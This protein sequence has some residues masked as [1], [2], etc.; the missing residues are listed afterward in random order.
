MIYIQYPDFELFGY[1][2]YSYLDILNSKYECKIF[3][4]QDKIKFKNEDIVIMI[5]NWS[6]SV[7]NNCSFEKN[8]KIFLFN[9]DTY[10]NHN[11][12]WELCQNLGR[13]FTNEITI[14]DYNPLNIKYFDL[15]NKF[16]NIKNLYFPFGYN[17]F[18][19]KI[20][21]KI[22]KTLEKDIDV[23]F[24]GWY[25]VSNRRMKILEE[26]SKFCKVVLIEKFD[27]YEQQCE[28]IKRSKI[29]LNIYFYENNKVFDYFRMSNLISN[30]IFTICEFPEN[31]DLEI[32]KNLIEYGKYL[33]FPKY[34]NI[35]EEVKKYLSI[36]EEERK[37]ISIKAKEWFK[38]NTNFSQN[39][40]NLM[41]EIYHIRE[42]NIEDY[43]H[44]LDLMYQFTNYEYKINLEEFK[45]KLINNPNLKVF[46]LI[47]QNKIIGS[48]SIFKLEK[49]HNNPVCL[50][51]DV[52]IN[53]NFRG[54]N[55][56]KIIIENLK[57]YG[58]N[59]WGC[60]KVILNCIESN[61][62]FYEKC[63]FHKCGV[64]FK[65]TN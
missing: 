45:Q 25:S 48:G 13:H 37:N 11:K 39:L 35:V 8:T 59:N 30:E 18:Y 40:I 56:G 4:S 62:G 51:E 2:T 55:Y 43:Q 47:N 36:T 54:K 29:V 32:E 19:T 24:Y 34:D 61:N 10:I 60:Y 7:I 38:L 65:F 41:D 9:I 22:Q 63:G 52:I 17:E 15:H 42:L 6:N 14:F 53:E 31:M 44:Y 12:Q 27:S 23:L 28:Y 49:L 16:K 58:I 64:Q 50:I 33:I 57:D 26:L 1:M 21:D 5:L 3:K 46:I 20:F